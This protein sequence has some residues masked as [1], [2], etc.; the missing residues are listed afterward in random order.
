MFWYFLAIYIFESNPRLNTATSSKIWDQ[1][2]I[3]SF[4]YLKF[5]CWTLSSWMSR[6]MWKL[7][8]KCNFLLLNLFSK[9]LA[10]LTLRLTAKFISYT[11]IL[12]WAMHMVKWIYF[13]FSKITRKWDEF[14]QVPRF[15]LGISLTL[16]GID[17]K[18][19]VYISSTLCL[20]WGAACRNFMK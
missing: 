13:R 8:V 9:V 5:L 16:P 2:L 1:I 14:Y 19:H 10:G 15:V 18:R 20:C 11:G 4:V 6:K 7:C 12:E 17:K 3:V